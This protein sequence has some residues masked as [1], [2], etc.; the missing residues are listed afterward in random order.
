ML[1]RLIRYVQT[2]ARFNTI[3]ERWLMAELWVAFIEDYGIIIHQWPLDFTLEVF[4]HYCRDGKRKCDAFLEQHHLSPKPTGQAKNCDHD[5]CDHDWVDVK[6][7]DRLCR[8]C[9]TGMRD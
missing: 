2:S 3:N 9:L 1:N 7:I 4:W 8:K 6:A 5:W